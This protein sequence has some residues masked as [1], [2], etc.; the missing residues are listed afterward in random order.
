MT[1]SKRSKEIEYTAYQRS[2]IE[3]FNSEITPGSIHLLLAPVGFGMSFAMVGAVSKLIREERISRVLVLSIAVLTTKWADLFD[4]R[5]VEPITIDSRALRLLREQLG[6]KADKWPT[7]VSLM[8][9]DLAKRSD[10]TELVS[11]VAWDLVVIDEAHVL[12]GQRLQLVEIL[13]EK[14]KPPSLLLATHIPSE[15]VMR[16]AESATVINWNKVVA[17]FRSSMDS[18]AGQMLLRETRSFRRSDEEVALADQTIAIAR[19]LGNLKGITLLKLASSSIS[20]LE[21]SLI[22]QV[23]SPE[24]Q[25]DQIELIEDLLEKVEQ[26]HVDSK[27][28]CFKILIKELVE[29]GVRHVVTFC[30]YRST[31][32]YLAPAV[33]RFG[34]Y[35]FGLHGGMNDKQRRETISRF[36]VEGGLLITT[37]AALKGMELN[38]V[39]A[40]I[41]YDLPTSPG[42]FYVRESRLHRYNRDLPCTVYFLED[43]R[44][45]LPMEGFLIRM[46]R[47]MDLD[48]GNLDIDVDAMFKETLKTP[49]NKTS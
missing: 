38:Y 6:S 18:S 43:E 31:L 29:S 24:S 41:H 34:F 4:R 14:T 40:A 42:M 47:K 25:S 30:N 22:R 35:D 1:H 32:D 36:E 10:A 12:S 46:I 17:E 19:K 26:L 15:N 45:A 9:I 44:R 33:E 3:Q 39:E 49:G 21:V 37:T 16:L 23:E 48:T 20:S 7:G 5:N 27:L 11:K 2:F 28:E 13:V 8:S